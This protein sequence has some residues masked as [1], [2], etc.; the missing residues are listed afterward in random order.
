MTATLTDKDTQI[1]KTA[2]TLHGLSDAVRMELEELGHPDEFLSH[3]SRV[4]RDHSQKLWDLV[5]VDDDPTD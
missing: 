2:A 1:L 3:L 4:L 5:E